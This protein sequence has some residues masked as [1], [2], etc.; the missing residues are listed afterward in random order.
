MSFA[1]VIPRPENHGELFQCVFQKLRDKVLHYGRMHASLRRNK[2]KTASSSSQQ[3]IT[4]QEVNPSFNEQAPTLGNFKYGTP[5]NSPRQ[6]EVEGGL[7]RRL[8]RAQG[9]GSTQETCNL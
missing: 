7:K 8:S 6:S 5:V 1:Q 3:R 9:D 4:Q 2:M